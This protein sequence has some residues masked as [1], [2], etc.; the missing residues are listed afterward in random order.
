MCPSPSDAPGSVGPFLPG[1]PVS[2]VKSEVLS[3]VDVSHKLEDHQQLTAQS[4]IFLLTKED[5]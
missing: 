1:R 5:C 4:V 3:D 2:S